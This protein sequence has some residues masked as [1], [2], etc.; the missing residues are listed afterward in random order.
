VDT[1]VVQGEGRFT[2]AWE[3][4]EPL[5]AVDAVEALI[6]AVRS[7]EPRKGPA[8]RAHEERTLKDRLYTLLVHDLKNP[9]SIIK[10]NLSMLTDFD[11]F[12]E[13]EKQACVKEAS[14]ATER[15]MALITDLLDVARAEE[16]Q[17]SSHRAECDLGALAREVA[18][19]HAQVASR[20]RVSVKVAAQ[21]PVLAPIDLSLVRR[22]LENIL[23]NAFRYVQKN[24]AIAIGV[25][26]EG[27]KAIVTIE[28]NGPQI[29]AG[30]LASLFDKYGDA[31][32]ADEVSALSNRGLGMYFCRLVLDA[33]HG[34]IRAFNQPAGVCFEFALPLAQ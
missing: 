16:G 32:R 22:V 23:N 5:D 27:G 8:P 13:V 14:G 17:L 2:Q 7:G 34:T 29:P 12:S 19:S 24:G 4:I 6:D 9:L 28:N 18:G 25:R 20:H 15:L 26:P 31:V 33:H 1:P 30:I 3:K 21:N 11:H 10:A